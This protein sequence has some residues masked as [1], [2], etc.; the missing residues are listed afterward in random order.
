MVWILTSLHKL[1]CILN[2]S[3]SFRQL[4]CHNSLFFPF[5]FFFL[6]FSA[7]W[8]P[9]FL[10]SLSSL[11]YNFNSLVVTIGFLSTTPLSGT[12]PGSWAVISGNKNFGNEITFK[13]FSLRLFVRISTIPLP[14]FTLFS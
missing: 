7:T 13:L 9:Q 12:S 6:P 8:L 1:I 2:F 5:S 10:F 11:P 3:P 4:G 14:K